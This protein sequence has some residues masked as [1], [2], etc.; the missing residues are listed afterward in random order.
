EPA[1]AAKPDAPATTMS[2][3]DAEAKY[4][5]TIEKRVSDILDA[6]KL[7][8]AT[9]TAKVHD[10]LIAQYRA[11]R[12]WQNANE[13]R[14]KDKSLTADQKQEIMA[15]RQ[16]LHDKFL[17]QLNAMLTPEHVETVKDKMTYGT[18]RVTYDAYC[19]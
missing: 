1:W 12:D 3:E 10:I 15:T 4:T 14:L 7:D 13:A 19:K 11:L 2:A 18:V 17:A 16:P 9:K 5:A 8:D 6:V